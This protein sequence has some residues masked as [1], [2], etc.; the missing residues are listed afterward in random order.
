[1]IHKI[2]TYTKMNLNTVKWAQWD[3]FAIQRTVMSVHMCVHCTVHNNGVNITA[4]NRP[5]NFPSYPLTPLLRWC[6]SERKGYVSLSVHCWLF[7]VYWWYS[8]VKGKLLNIQKRHFW[9]LY[10]DDVTRIYIT[11]LV[12][13]E[14]FMTFYRGLYHVYCNQLFQWSR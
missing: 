10:N 3:K 11:L 2:H 1:V 7:R 4:Q 5:D 8:T 14:Y 9:R 12:H 13:T 6:L